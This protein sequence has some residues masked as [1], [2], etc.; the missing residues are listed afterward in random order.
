MLL[1]VL[2]ALARNVK[3]SLKLQQIRGSSKPNIVWGA[4]WS[5]G[6]RKLILIE[7]TLNAAKYTCS[8]GIGAPAQRNQHVLQFLEEHG[9]VLLSDWPAQSPYFIRIENVE[10]EVKRL[11][12][13]QVLCGKS[14]PWEA[15]QK[16]F[17][18]MSN[19]VAC[20]LKLSKLNA[21]L[22]N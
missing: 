12:S 11:V 19:Q 15:M 13:Q 17:Y 9:V 2:V 16:T 20:L 10:A 8:V 1:H 3:S 4:I 14:E 22:E 5:T 18:S 6:M 21:V 7:G